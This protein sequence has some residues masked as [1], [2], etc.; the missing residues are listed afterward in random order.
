[1][2]ASTSLPLAPKRRRSVLPPLCAAAAAA[3]LAGA[4]AGCVP[5]VV[6]GAAAAGVGVMAADRRSSGAQLDDQGIE[7]RSAARIREIANDQ[8]DITT[9]SFNRQLLLVGTVGSAADKARVEEAVR[10]TP[11]VRAVINEVA[12]GPSLSFGRRSNDALITAKVKG[13]LLEARDVPG[14]S[15][16]V[17]TDNG[18]VYLMGLATR[19]ELERATDIARGVSGVVKVVRTVEVLTEAQLGAGAAESPAAIQPS[20][21]PGS[22]EPQPAPPAG[23]V[24]LPPMEPLPAPGTPPATPASPGVVVNP[25][26]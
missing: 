19:H 17:V 5:L 13:S 9:I 15:F 3:V 21:V 4:L 2:T 16:K 24:P 6:G 26:R 23:H 22:A 8:M 25:V 10:G 18:V 7:L 14:H 12:V 11:N 20:A 1:M